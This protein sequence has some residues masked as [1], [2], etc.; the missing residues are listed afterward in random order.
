VPYQY[1]SYK[2]ASAVVTDYQYSSAFLVISVP[3][4]T[5]HVKEN[6]SMRF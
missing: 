4:P 1:K 5:N 6:P 3:L 2:E